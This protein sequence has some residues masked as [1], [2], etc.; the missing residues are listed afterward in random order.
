MPPLSRIIHLPL[1]VLNLYAGL[2]GN[3]QLWQN[4]QVTAIEQ[5]EK[6]ARAYQENFPSDRVIIANA[7][8]YL[9]DHYSEYDFIWSSPPCQKHSRMMIATRHKVADFIPLE[10]YQEIIFL[11]HFY[12]GRWTV[13]NVK[14]YYCP[15]IPPDKIIGRHYIWS[16][17][18]IPDFTLPPFKAFI[19]VSTTNEAQKLKQW[20]GISYDRPIYYEGNHDPVQVLRNC[21]HPLMGNHILKAAFWEE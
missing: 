15:L 7:H 18:P 5:N 16:N 3:R 17:F 14:P 4:V 9:K 1:K 13:E 8:T 2:G 11:K 19:T 12:K 20:L 10:L 6:I 21:V